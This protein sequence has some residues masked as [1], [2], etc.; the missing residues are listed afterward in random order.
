MERRELGFQTGSFPQGLK[1]H[2]HRTGVI[3]KEGEL[4]QRSAETLP[5]T[6]VLPSWPGVMTVVGEC[7]WPSSRE[8][9][10]TRPLW[11][12][13]TPGCSFRQSIS[14]MTNQSICRDELSFAQSSKGDSYSMKT[15]ERNPLD[16]LLTPVAHLQAEV[17]SL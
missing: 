8:E 13:I 4:P 1:K 2:R 7:T 12:K 10:K 15:E 9:G 11:I 5:E 17:K 14:Q 6:A 16:L 3:R